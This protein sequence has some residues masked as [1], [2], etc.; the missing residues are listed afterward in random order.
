MVCRT[1]QSSAFCRK[2]AILTSLA[3]GSTVHFEEIYTEGIS[4]ITTQDFKYAQKLG[5]VVKLLATSYKKDGKV[6]AMTAPFMIESSHP[7]YNVND[8]LNGIYVNGNVLGNVMFF[9][10]GAGKLPTASAVVSDV[11]D[12]VKHKGTNVMTV[13]SNRELELG[14]TQDEVRSFFVR[15]KGSLDDL[16]KIKENF[17]NVKTVTVEDIEDEFGFVTQDMTEK[18]FT[19]AAKNIPM[20]SRIRI[21]KTVFS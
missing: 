16:T 9:G 18:E 1:G 17:G 6:Y 14:N 2:I 7:L 5:Y 13:W 4:H 21:D 11:V 12:C 10:A 15:V 8:V 20:I 19:E 3:Y